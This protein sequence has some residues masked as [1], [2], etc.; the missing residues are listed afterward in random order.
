MRDTTCVI[1]AGLPVP[2][3]G[4]PFLPGPTFSG[5]YH[6]SGEPETSPSTYGRYHN[7]TWSRL[8]QALGELEADQPSCLL[9]AWLPSQRFLA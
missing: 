1:L 7:P 8:E 5:T 3:Q 4:E 2:A 9:P 6:F